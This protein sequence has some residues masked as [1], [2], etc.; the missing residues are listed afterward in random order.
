MGK[1]TGPGRLRSTASARAKTRIKTSATR[2]IFTFVQNAERMS[3]NDFSN[4]SRSKNACLTS[5]QPGERTTT[6]ATTA[7]RPAVET[8]ATATLRP[9]PPFVRL[10]RILEP[11]FPFSPALLQDRGALLPQ[12]PDLESLER[13]VGP[14]LPDRL[15]DAIDERVPLLEDEAVDLLDAALVRE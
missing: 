11:R 15:V 7:T 1:K 6:T 13:P 12:P 8:R 9:P 5:S 3:G 4:C 2:K 14:H 10:P